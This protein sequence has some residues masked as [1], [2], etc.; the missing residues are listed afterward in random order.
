MGVDSANSACSAV[1]NSLRL[2]HTDIEPQSSRV[3]RGKT[4][5]GVDSAYLARYAVGSSPRLLCFDVEPQ[6]SRVRR[7]NAWM[8]VDSANSACSAVRS[9]LR[10][11]CFGVE[12]ADIRYQVIRQQRGNAH[13]CKPS[14]RSMI[15]GAFAENRK[16]EVLAHKGLGKGWCSH[17]G[18][19]SASLLGVTRLCGIMR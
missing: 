1:G 15:L 18:Q 12:Q 6:S 14:G 11:R 3:R 5:M 9:S 19:A 16:G 13:S 10:Q 17:R 4:L 7:G 2:W 8:G